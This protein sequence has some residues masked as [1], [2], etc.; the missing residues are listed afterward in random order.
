MRASRFLCNALASTCF[1]LANG[2]ASADST[3]SAS[4]T[5][6]FAHGANTG[7]VD[8]R[9]DIG[10]P[11]EGAV[12]TDFF[13]GGFVYG[14]NVGWIDFGDNPPAD[15]VRYQNTGVADFGV[16]HDG[17]GNLSGLGYGANVGWISFG[18]PSPTWEKPPVIDLKTGEFGGYAYGSNIGWID[19]GENGL[20][21]TKMGSNARGGIARFGASGSFFYT[22]K[23]NMAT[24]R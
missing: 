24:S 5:G 12:V 22:V 9:W 20:Y 6:R 4:G 19:L 10:S 3:I 16:N 23:T 1:L 2:S 7:W 14:A 11:G 17:R 13:L 8:F 15:G 21:N 18:N